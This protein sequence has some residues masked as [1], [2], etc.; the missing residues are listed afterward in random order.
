[1]LVGEGQVQYW[2]KLLNEKIWNGHSLASQP[3]DLPA[4]P[5]YDQVHAIAKLLR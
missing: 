2:I 1:M 4:N 3:G 5:L